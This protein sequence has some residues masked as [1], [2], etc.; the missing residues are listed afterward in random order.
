MLARSIRRPSP[1][2][3][4][5]DFFPF[6]PRAC[7]LPNAVSPFR[8]RAS[9]ESRRRVRAATRRSGTERTGERASERASAAAAAAWKRGEAKL[10]GE[11]CYG[12]GRDGS[13]RG[14]TRGGAGNAGSSG[15]RLYYS[16]A[17]LPYPRRSS[18]K[19]GAAR[20]RQYQFWNAPTSTEIH[21]R[22]LGISRE[23]VGPR[24]SID[25]SKNIRRAA[26]AR[27]NVFMYITSGGGRGK[28]G[29]SVGERDDGGGIR[30]GK[31]DDALRADDAERAGG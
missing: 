20:D 3:S 24:G 27:L 14:E 9:G 13:V 23:N 15:V 25:L 21:K 5:A 31:G 11:R 16:R 22:D 17:L 4:P 18:Q 19:L 12:T 6:D 30:G 1:V 7:A 26:G 2:V 29:G 8:F 10:R 28:G